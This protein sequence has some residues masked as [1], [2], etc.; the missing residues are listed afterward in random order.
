MVEIN[1]KTYYC[2]QAGAEGTHNNDKT[3]GRRIMS[4][5]TDDHT[6]FGGANDGYVRME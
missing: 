6:V 3:G 5:A 4:T 2:D 1:G